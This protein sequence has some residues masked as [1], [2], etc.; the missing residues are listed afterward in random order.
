MSR[1]TSL[2]RLI[3]DAVRPFLSYTQRPLLTLACLDVSTWRFPEPGVLSIQ[4]YD[5]VNYPEHIAILDDDIIVAGYDGITYSH[6]AI[7]P[8]IYGDYHLPINNY[9]RDLKTCQNKLLIYPYSQYLYF[10][11]KLIDLKYNT[12]RTVCETPTGF[13]VLSTT[14]TMRQN[15]YIR[16]L[17]VFYENGVNTH[18]VQTPHLWKSITWV[19]KGNIAF[20]ATRTL[21]DCAEVYLLSID[22]EVLDLFTAETDGRMGISVLYDPLWDEYLI[23]G[24]NCIM[25]LSE[26]GTRIV[27]EYDDSDNSYYLHAL[28]W[29]N[30]RSLLFCIRNQNILAQIEM[31]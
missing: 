4:Y 10:G 19:G 8:S 21:M 7:E 23:S 11:D 30:K 1:L 14:G 18:T 2:F 17:L 22:G 5:T 9:Q 26:W 31:K 3:P 16:G 27:Y 20:A 24:D 6:V 25:A 12:G 28:T 13:V 15:E 29:L